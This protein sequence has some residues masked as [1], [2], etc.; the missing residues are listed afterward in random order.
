MVESLRQVTRNF[1][2][3]PHNLKV[4]TIKYSRCSSL[5]KSVHLVPIVVVFT[6]FDQLI[7]RMEEYLS[8]EEL[9]LSDDE[10]GQLCLQKAS[11][12]FEKLCLEPL[13]KVDSKLIYSKTSGLQIIF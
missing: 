4:R 2:S 13:R 8:D 11:A 5:T 12:E 6:Q 9:N 3:S 10:I 7:S 1:S